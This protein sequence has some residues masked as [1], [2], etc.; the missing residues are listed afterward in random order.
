MSKKLRSFDIN[1]VYCIDCIKD[2]RKLS[3][4]TIGAM[5]TDPPYGLEFMGTEWDRFR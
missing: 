1:R 4:D 3:E 5:V 2:M